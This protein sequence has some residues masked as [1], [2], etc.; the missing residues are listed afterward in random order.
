M[1]LASLNVSHN[2]AQRAA[3]YSSLIYVWQ[4]SLDGTHR[5]QQALGWAALATPATGIGCL[6]GPGASRREASRRAR[7]LSPAAPRM[8]RRQLSGA[9]KNAIASRATSLPFERRRRA[10][11]LDAKTSVSYTAVG[12]RYTAAAAQRRYVNNSS[13]AP[14]RAG[15]R[16]RCPGPSK[17]CFPTWAK[18]VAYAPRARPLT[19]ATHR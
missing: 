2:N 6:C 7:L 11:H 4:A 19:A 9:A 5:W 10:P 17:N 8:L 12:S 16:A 13:N 18:R 1:R 15:C 14:G 3:P